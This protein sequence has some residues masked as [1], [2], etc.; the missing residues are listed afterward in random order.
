VPDSYGKR[1]RQ[2]VKARK[3]AARDERRVARNQRQKEREIT[4][5]VG[6]GAPIEAAE[7]DPDLAPSPPDA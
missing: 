2:A 3:A 5:T 1:N 6:E 4:G 7:P